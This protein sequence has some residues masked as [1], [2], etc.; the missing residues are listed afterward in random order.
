MPSGNMRAHIIGVSV[1][2]TTS[3]IM[4]ETARVIANS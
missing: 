4:I 2:D 3:E 1:S